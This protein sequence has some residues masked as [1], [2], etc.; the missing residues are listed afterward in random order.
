VLARVWRERAKGEGGAG[1]DRK[2]ARD[3]RE[4]SSYRGFIEKGAVVAEDLVVDFEHCAVCREL[5]GG[6]Q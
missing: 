1:K 2:E 6:E 3:V 4:R 5:G